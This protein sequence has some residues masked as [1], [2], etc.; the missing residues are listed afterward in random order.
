VS[1]KSILPHY[2]TIERVKSAPEDAPIVSERF[3]CDVLVLMQHF[4]D[5][6]PLNEE[7]L[8]PTNYLF[9]KSDGKLI[10]ERLTPALT[11]LL[12]IPQA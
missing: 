12:G 1:F 9:W 11:E 4:A 6:K 8:Q 10:V 7:A 2:A 5:G 3:N